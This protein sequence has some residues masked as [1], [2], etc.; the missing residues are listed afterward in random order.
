M[1]K[2]QISVRI[3]CSKH[4][5]EFIQRVSTDVNASQHLFCLECVLQQTQDGA[6]SSSTLKNIPDFVDMAAQFYSQHKQASTANTSDV[7]DEYIGLLSKQADAIEALSGHIADE[8]KKSGD[9]V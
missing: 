3:P 6:I 5:S 4:S 8:K 7:P 9:R 1:D 2:Q